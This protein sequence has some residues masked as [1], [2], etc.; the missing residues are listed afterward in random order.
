MT[1]FLKRSNPYQRLL[2][3]EI[4]KLLQTQ[5]YKKANFTWFNPNSGWLLGL[6][7]PDH[8]LTV[9]NFARCAMCNVNNSKITAE[10]KL[11]TPCNICD[12]YLYNRSTSRGDSFLF[13]YL[14]ELI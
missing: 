13:I 3:Q 11:K 6:T 12:I 7:A 10:K 1:P 5:E 14:H 8:K 2:V 4:T 9:D